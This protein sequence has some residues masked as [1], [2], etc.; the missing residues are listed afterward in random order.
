M[1]SRDELIARIE[2]STMCADD[3]VSEG[4]QGS[5]INTELKSVL[6]EPRTIVRR[7]PVSS[8]DLRERWRALWSLLD[9]SN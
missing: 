8:G 6:E 2:S 3:F 4:V 7:P 1:R 9:C 5:G